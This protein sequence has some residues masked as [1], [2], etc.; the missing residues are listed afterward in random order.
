VNRDLD[1]KLMLRSIARSTQVI[2]KMFED[3]A[4]QHQLEGKRL[5]WIARLGQLFWGLVEVAVPGSLLNL[6]FRH[7]LKLLYAFELLL[8]GGSI[9]FGDKDINS[10]GW[11]AFGVTVA[12]NIVVL[13][14]GDYIR[15]RGRWWRALLLLFGVAIVFLAAVGLGE[16]LG[17]DW[18]SR[19]LSM[20]S[21][22]MIWL[23]TLWGSP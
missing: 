16:L 13:L 5:A 2:G 1:P 9:L 21:M 17:R 10:F 14:L 22:A 20:W 12:M 3:I 7:W 8:I 4:N 19:I 6:L 23:R 15:G 18:G 11:K